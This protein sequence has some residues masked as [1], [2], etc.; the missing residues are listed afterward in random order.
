MVFSFVS[1]VYPST[2]NTMQYDPDPVK[3]FLLGLPAA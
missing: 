2:K 1:S 3:N